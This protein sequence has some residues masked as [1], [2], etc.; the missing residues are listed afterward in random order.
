MLAFIM[1]IGRS[2]LFS[3]PAASV[4][5]NKCHL[6][7]TLFYDNFIFPKLVWCLLILQ[8]VKLITNL[9]QHFFLMTKYD[10]QI[11]KAANKVC[12]K[13][14]GLQAEKT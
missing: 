1:P 14:A 12:T 4:A 2:D 8:R 3:L 13:V 9:S 5:M 7:S 10:I 11:T 6:F